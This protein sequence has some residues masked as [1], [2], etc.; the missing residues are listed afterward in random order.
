MLGLNDADRKKFE[1]I[2]NKYAQMKQ[3][4]FARWAL[5]M[6][7]FEKELYRDPEQ[8]LN[9]LWWQLVKKYQL[10]NKPAK[11][12]NPDWAAKIHFSIAPCYYHNY[13][14]GEL[15]ASQIHHYI[16]HEVMLLESDRNFGYCGH[17]K[18]GDYLKKKIF[19]PGASLSWND[20]IQFATGETLSAKYFVQQ[21]ITKED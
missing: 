10:V 8:D 17:E 11:R 4:I 21:F 14:L 13:L 2:G 18:I 16:V 3:L 1:E 9:T 6:Y 20:M 15:L 7:N 12:N 19:E 5:V